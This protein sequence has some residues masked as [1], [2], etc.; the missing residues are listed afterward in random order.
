MN[1]K[2]IK[3]FSVAMKKQPSSILRHVVS[4]ACCHQVGHAMPVKSKMTQNITFA[5]FGHKMMSIL[6]QSL[7]LDAKN[8]VIPGF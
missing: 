6:Q 8:T 4:G 1:E 5:K 2:R 7:S 3:Y